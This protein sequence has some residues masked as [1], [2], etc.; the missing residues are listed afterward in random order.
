MDLTVTSLRAPEGVKFD[1]TRRSVQE[2][3]SSLHAELSTETADSKTRMIS[4][5]HR[6]ENPADTANLLNA[7][8][9][10]PAQSG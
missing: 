4:V 10:Y 6:H 2:T 7:S 8:L 3:I 9:S 5:I 1:V